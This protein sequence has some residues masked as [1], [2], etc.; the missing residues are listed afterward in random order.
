MKMLE[1]TLEK[2]T[3]RVCVMELVHAPGKMAQSTMVTGI[4]MC[5][6]EWE[7]TALVMVLL[8][9]KVLLLTTR[10][11]EKEPKLRRVESLSVEL[12]KTIK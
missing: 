2:R 5:A 3:L 8:F 10:N 7:L 9:M 4:R 12:G 6:M 1:I 11:M